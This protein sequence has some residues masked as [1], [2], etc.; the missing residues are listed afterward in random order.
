MIKSVEI[1]FQSAYK[2]KGMTVRM[3]RTVSSTRRFTCL[4]QQA[5]FDSTC[6]RDSDL[7]LLFSLLDDLVGIGIADAGQFHELLFCG[8][9]DIHQ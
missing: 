8:T 1:G 3:L 5:I 7:L 6:N 2:R 9:V 4:L